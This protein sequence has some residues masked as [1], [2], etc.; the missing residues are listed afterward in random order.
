M[1]ATGKHSLSQ[2]PFEFYSKILSETAYIRLINLLHYIIGDS[3]T[4]IAMFY[5]EGDYRLF[6]ASGCSIVSIS[7]LQNSILLI[8][9]ISNYLLTVLEDQWPANNPIMLHYALLFIGIK[10]VTRSLSFH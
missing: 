5:Q 10:Y 7:M 1:A 2:D 6:R 8:L 4:L 9:E 3:C